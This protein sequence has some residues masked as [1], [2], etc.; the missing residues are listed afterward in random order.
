MKHLV[1]PCSLFLLASVAVAAGC[2]STSAQSPSDGGGGSAAVVGT[3][4]PPDSTGWVDGMGTGT[5]MIQGAWYGYG[6]STGP[7]GTT[8]SGDCEK[9]G[10]HAVAE[11]SMIIT[12][13]F[14]SFPN[15]AGKMCTKGVAAKV[16]PMAGMTAGDY[17]NMWGAGIALDLNNTG[18]DAGVKSPYNA[19]ANHVTGFGFTIDKVPLAG[20][21][22]ELPTAA[23]GSSSAFWG[24][25]MNAPSPL[26][27][28]RN[29]FRWIDVSGPFYLT[30]PPPFDP[31]TI[32]S[33]QF[34][35]ATGTGSESPYEFC[36][37]DLTALTN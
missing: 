2:S 36:I 17:T 34:H 3:P 11:C 32:M 24:G 22:V 37:S 6:D 5:T 13:P 27:A 16:L 9:L 19:N 25:S 8:A 33:L 4:L 14:G 10:G 21:R 28:G 26:H 23:T 31:T 29:E 18:G 15:T 35:V 12:P 7:D 20:I 30:S 1:A